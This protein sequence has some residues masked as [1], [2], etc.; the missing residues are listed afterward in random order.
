MIL[1]WKEIIRRSLRALSGIIREMP[2]EKKT[3]HFIAVVNNGRFCVEFTSVINLPHDARYHAT[4]LRPTLVFHI[5]TLP[6]YPKYPHQVL[7]Y[8]EVY[9]HRSYKH[10][11]YC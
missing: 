3:G 9:E 1:W 4:F 6:F 10:N 8:D 7:K 5:S 2:I 11:H